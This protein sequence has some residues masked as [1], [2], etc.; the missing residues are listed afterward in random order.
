MSFSWT[1]VC[2]IIQ[3][4]HV[5]SLES[6]K[7]SIF[8]LFCSGCH[9]DSLTV[10]AVKITHMSYW[11]GQMLPGNN[12]VILSVKWKNLK[13]DLLSYLSQTVQVSSH[14]ESRNTYC[15]F[16]TGSCTF[17]YCCTFFVKT[18]TP[19]AS[20]YYIFITSITKMTIIRS[21]GFKKWANLNYDII[22]LL[23]LFKGNCL[24]TQYD[25]G[26]KDLIDIHYIVTFLGRFVVTFFSPLKVERVVLSWYSKIILCY[27]FKNGN[28]TTGWLWAVLKG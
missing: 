20:E 10:T 22:W 25:G 19:E 13:D 17:C 27:T 14:Q 6:S 16:W 3:R 11:R 7:P 8:L 24:D 15:Y 18:K 26:S 5:R 2:N 28:A 12:I 9:Q 21:S 1:C 23:R 4:L